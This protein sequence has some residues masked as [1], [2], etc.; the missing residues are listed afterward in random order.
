[1]NLTDYEDPTDPYAPDPRAS[2]RVAAQKR[3]RTDDDQS[4]VTTVRPY[5][6]IGLLAVAAL[7]IGSL[8]YGLSRQAPRPLQIGS[9]APARAF[10]IDPKLGDVASPA[11]RTATEAPRPPT[12]TPMPTAPFVA[13][14]EIEPQTGRGLTID[15]IIDATAT[16]APAPEPPPAPSYID[17][18]GAQAEHSPRGGLCGPTGGD[19]APGVPFGVDGSQYIQNVGQQAPHKVR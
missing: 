17:N 14:P 4:S 10:G 6:P 19:C 8:S 12:F 9:T 15:T 16:P 13:A 7:L 3:R 18:V 1:M 11:L 5:L 2:Q